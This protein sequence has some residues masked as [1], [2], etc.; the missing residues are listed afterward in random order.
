MNFLEIM[1]VIFTVL[2]SIFILI[3]L[4]YCII[5]L[6]RKFNVWRFHKNF[7]KQINQSENGRNTINSN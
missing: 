6:T 3:V 5:E 2:I 1:G 4:I 7:M